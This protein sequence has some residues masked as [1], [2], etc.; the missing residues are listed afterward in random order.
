MPQDLGSFH[1]KWRCENSTETQKTDINLTG[2]KT[3]SFWMLRD[4]VIT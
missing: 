1:A 2:E 4:K 3:M